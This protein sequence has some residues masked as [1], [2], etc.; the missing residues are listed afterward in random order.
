[1]IEIFQCF[2]KMDEDW[3]MHDSIMSEEVHMNEQNKDDAGV[4][5]EHIDCFDAF[6]TSSVL[7]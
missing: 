6:N 4:N 2:V 5:E 3:Y 1:M 7:I